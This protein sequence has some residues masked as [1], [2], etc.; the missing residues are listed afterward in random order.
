MFKA[1][2]K[3]SDLKTIAHLNNQ[4]FVSIELLESPVVV[5]WRYVYS[6]STRDESRLYYI[7]IPGYHLKIDGRYLWMVIP[8]R[9]IRS[10]TTQYY[11]IPPLKPQF[12]GG[13]ASWPYSN[14]IGMGLVDAVKFK[15]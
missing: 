9:N 2:L 6:Y 5:I 7:I 11:A 12:G 13:R 4:G 10:R 1:I 14:M 15:N 3:N 8:R